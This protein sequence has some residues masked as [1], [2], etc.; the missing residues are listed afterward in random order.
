MMQPHC[1]HSSLKSQ[2]SIKSAQLSP[3]LILN[4]GVSLTI[5]QTLL[6]K[7]FYNLHS[8]RTVGHE[9]HTKVCL[10]VCIW[11]KLRPNKAA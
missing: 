4:K 9:K 8:F 2:S 11:Y 5:P 3:C 1:F 10:Q 6:K 7:T